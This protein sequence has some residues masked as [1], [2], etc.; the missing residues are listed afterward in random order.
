MA[1]K[2]NLDTSTKLDIT[3]RGGDNFEFTATFS[4]NNS[5]H[6]DFSEIFNGTLLVTNP[7]L[8]LN[9]TV[10]KFHSGSAPTNTSFNG[11]DIFD[12]ITILNDN[13]SVVKFEASG[14]KMFIPKGT[15]SYVFTMLTNFG[16]IH[17]FL[18]GKF[19]VI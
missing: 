10:R 4:N 7:N 5:S 16:K 3:C 17:T 15:Y 13:Q 9:Q 18:H 12:S 11:I 19:K 8:G 1:S 2:L 6:I 14:Y